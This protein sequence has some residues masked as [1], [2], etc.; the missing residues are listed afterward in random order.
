MKRFFGAFTRLLVLGMVFM[1]FLPVSLAAEITNPA[2][3]PDLREEVKTASDGDVIEINGTRI[4]SAEAGEQPWIIDKNITIRGTSDDA[5]ISLRP[6]GILLNADVTFENVDFNFGSS[7]C[8]AIMANGYTLTLKDVGSYAQNVY[9]IHLFCGGLQNDD[10][11]STLGPKGKI[12]L[13]G[14]CNLNGGN[15]YA[16]HLCNGGMSPE[17]GNIDGPSTNYAADP[18]IEVG[19]TIDIYAG[20]AQQ[21]NIPGVEGK[22]VFLTDA[23]KY[24]V[25]GTVNITLLNGQARVH[26]AGATD[27]SVTFKA[28]NGNEASPMLMDISKLTVNSGNLKPAEGSSFRESAAIEIKPDAKLN[29]SD[30]GNFSIN[31]F[32]GVGYLAL[33]AS[34]TMTITG[35]ATGSTNVCIG[36]FSY[37]NASLVPA[38]PQQTYIIARNAPDDAFVL[39]PY[40]T[41]PNMKLIKDSSNGYWKAFAETGEILVQS[42]A[43]PYEQKT[44]NVN[45]GY[46]EL[47]LDICFSEETAPNTYLWD[48]PVEL[49]VND[50][51]A[52]K[53]ETSGGF[54][55]AIGNDETLSLSIEHNSLLILPDSTSA[56]PEGTYRIRIDIPSEHSKTGQAL[57]ASVTLEVS[58]AP[59]KHHVT[60]KGS[61]AGETGAGD[62][63]AD[64]TVSIDAGAKP[65]YIFTGWTGIADW[66]CMEEIKFTDSK[67]VSTDFEM[68]ANDIIITANWEQIPPTFDYTINSIYPESGKVTVSVTANTQATGILIIAAYSDTGKMIQAAM[69]E[70]NG[71]ATVPVNVNTDNAAYI[72][73]FIVDSNNSWKPVCQCRRQDIHTNTN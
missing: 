48:I 23:Q 51:R 70:L 60:V 63:E 64:T 20:G 26:S 58:N 5:L 24:K 45:D 15:I 11:K 14:T 12:V 3:A 2:S 46:A 4:V 39:R 61:A 25:S 35:V 67:N 1:L 31:D 32:T 28:G 56:I 16:G 13:Q 57:Q 22:K 65:G 33:G 50:R 17:T 42:L 47:L 41:Q 53:D 52:L 59:T 62:Y 10:Y 73:A 27:T 29:L 44:V 6:S 38:I 37:E 69:A 8:H 40:G 21:K 55:A 49:Y 66:E 19:T 36:G 72:K 71:T 18:E 7:T 34:Q 9:P 43:F 30:C 54:I 68:P